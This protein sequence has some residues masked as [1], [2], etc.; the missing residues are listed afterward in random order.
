MGYQAKVSDMPDP[1]GPPEATGFGNDPLLS[2]STGTTGGGP[3]TDG[4]CAMDD[5]CYNC[6]HIRPNGFWGQAEAI[7]WW[8][9][10]SQSPP[11]LSTGPANPPAP[12]PPATTGVLPGATVLFPTS[13]LNQQNRFGGRFTLGYWLDDCETAGFVGNIFMLGTQSHT[14]TAT[15]AGT[16]SGI[17]ARPFFNTQTQ[18]E[19]A[20]IL[21]YPGY[22]SGSA[23]V[24][25][26]TR[27]MGAE[28]NFRQAL[29]GNR[30]NRIDGIMGYRFLRLDDSLIMNTSTT[31]LAGSPFNGTTL[32][33]NDTFGTKNAFN[34]GQLGLMWQYNEGRWGL[35]TTAKV[36]LGG[37]NE[38]VTVAGTTAVTPAGGPTTTLTG[39]FLALGSNSGTYGRTIFSTIPEINTNLTYQLN[40]I[41]QLNVGYTFFVV[42]S[43]LRASDQIDRN[44]NP[45]QFPPPGAG[46]NNTP[47]NPNHNLFSSDLWV[48]GINF[49]LNCRF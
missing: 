38:R 15:G 7:S 32:A 45:Q 27:L 31:G 21:A 41:W 22:S 6:W 24:A 47:P 20:G 42:T 17:L 4:A 43:V 48:Q 46:T 5:D 18:A 3:C 26:Q 10:G 29:I 19:D 40:D 12:P 14:Y 2:N 9:R 35:N 37:L 16:S 13:D 30:N 23:A 33:T 36:A 39:G 28:I 49:G 8:V 1:P 44:L 25:T 34:G 11:L